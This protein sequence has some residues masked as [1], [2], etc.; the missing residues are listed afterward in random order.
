MSGG[1]SRGRPRGARSGGRATDGHHASAD[2][3]AQRPSRGKRSATAIDEPQHDNDRYKRV[4][5]TGTTGKETWFYHC[6]YC[7]AI[8]PKSSFQRRHMHCEARIAYW[9]KR[10]LEENAAAQ[11]RFV[12]E[13]DDYGVDDD[14]IA[15]ESGR[16]QR[17]LRG[18]SPWF[19]LKLLVE[20]TASS[21]NEEES[22]NLGAEEAT[23]REGTIVATKTVNNKAI[24]VMEMDD[25][26]QVCNIS[27]P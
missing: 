13:L 5:G 17:I 24:Y 2:G 7:P 22:P 21:S 4:K 11:Q 26:T 10:H 25:G 6:K 15:E 14:D 19:G 16:V 23:P 9:A 3:S 1:R 20:T 12:N 27:A 8:L 18:L